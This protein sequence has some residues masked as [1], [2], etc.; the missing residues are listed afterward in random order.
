MFIYRIPAD[1]SI[2]EAGLFTLPTLSDTFIT[3]RLGWVD[4]IDC[5]N[6]IEPGPPG[7]ICLGRRGMFEKYMK[8]M[9]IVLQINIACKRCLEVRVLV[10]YYRDPCYRVELTF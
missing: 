9:S 8:S 2:N 10:Y 6:I 7:R 3:D 5:S 1:S 4:I